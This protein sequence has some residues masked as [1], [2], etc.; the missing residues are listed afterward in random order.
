MNNLSLIAEAALGGVHQRP[1]G[2]ITRPGW[3]L[4][5]GHTTAWVY[6]PEVAFYGTAF[7]NWSV[8][9]MGEEWEFGSMA[10]A[11]DW[12]CA[13]ARSSRPMILR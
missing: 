13:Q 4:D 8:E 7:P 5:F 10:E 3:Q 6:P 2:E 9:W 1:I 12:L 11:L